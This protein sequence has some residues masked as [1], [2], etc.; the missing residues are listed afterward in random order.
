VK[1]SNRKL[2]PQKDRMNNPPSVMF[3]ELHL[4]RTPSMATTKRS[5]KKLGHWKVINAP[6]VLL[7]AIPLKVRMEG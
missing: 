1:T 6:K 3:L 2:P 7:L 5:K 4:S